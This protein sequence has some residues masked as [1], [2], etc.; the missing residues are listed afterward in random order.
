MSAPFSHVDAFTAVPFVGNPAG[1]CL[2]DAAANAGWMQRVAAE[3]GL[4][5]HLA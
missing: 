5:G 2:L 1:V 3:I 4:C